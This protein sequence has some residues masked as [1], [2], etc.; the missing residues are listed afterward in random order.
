GLRAL[1]P[2][3]PRTRHVSDRRSSPREQR[4][5]GVRHHHVSIKSAVRGAAGAGPGAAESRHPR[6]TSGASGGALTLHP[7]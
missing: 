1:L 4:A 3:P 6:S 7:T 2:P 5:N